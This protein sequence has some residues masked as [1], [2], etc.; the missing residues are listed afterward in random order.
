VGGMLVYVRNRGG[1]AHGSL[2][3][4]GVEERCR[5]WEVDSGKWEVGSAKACLMSHRAF[6]AVNELP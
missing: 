5:E 3:T 2:V 6:I 1:A 4:S